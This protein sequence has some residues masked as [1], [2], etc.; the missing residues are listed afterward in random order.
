LEIKKIYNSLREKIIWLD[1]VPEKVLNISELADS[2]GVSRTPIKEALI[3]LQA[4]GWVLRH[5]THFMVTPLSLDRI[6]SINEMRSVLEVQAYRWAMQRITN[7]EIDILNQIEHEMKIIKP[8][9]GRKRIVELDFKLHTTLYKATRNNQLSE[10]LERLLSQ[11]IRFW[12]S[13]QKEVILSSLFEEPM[14]IIKAIKE[15]NPK[16][17][18]ILTEKHIKKTMDDLLNPL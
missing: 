5:S 13:L 15:K 11:Y 8:D 17:L 18:S 16:D 7:E 3:Y 10:L 14:K 4:E 6:K 12:L 2:F 1:L 9:A